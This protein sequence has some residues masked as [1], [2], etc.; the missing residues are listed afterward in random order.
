[1]Q[2]LLLMSSTIAPPSTGGEGGR[3][4]R[5]T[6]GAAS[7][8]LPFAE[9]LS[10]AHSPVLPAGPPAAGDVT[11]APPGKALPATGQILPPAT[12]GHMPAVT[13]V[14]ESPHTG[15]VA[16]DTA[17]VET[18]AVGDLDSLLEMSA[19]LLAAPQPMAGQSDAKVL[20]EASRGRLQ[21]S[22]AR[23]G[24]LAGDGLPAPMEALSIASPALPPA[25]LV[26]GEPA[27]IRNKLG[28]AT[29]AARSP[30]VTG[31]PPGLE[32]QGTRLPEQLDIPV[33][34]SQALPR[35]D[36]PS[37]L[38]ALDNLSRLAALQGTA[39]EP[40]AQPAPLLAEATPL[41]TSTAKAAA[42]GYPHAGLEPG[43]E[44][45]PGEIVLQV[46]TAARAS[47]GLHEATLQLHPAEL[48]RLQVTINAEGD[49]ARVVFTADNPLAK[50][51]IEAS[52][53]RLRDLLAQDGLQLV[54]AEVGHQGQSSGRDPDT[55]PA[56][57]ANIPFESSTEQAAEP[58][59]ETRVAATRLLDY[60]A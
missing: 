38:S 42:A 37:E 11:S 20:S 41:T 1:M 10:R 23:V 47:G 50:D 48:G 13:Q 35:A 7:G 2:S 60:Y 21:Q 4:S 28:A 55:A 22:S 27:L 16:P 12:A 39:A 52:L 49:Q 43:S 53:P 8:Q 45:F 17:E 32:S 24:G 6:P 19:A 40:G 18:P 33:R 54:Q 5:E 3:L 57:A 31:E 14:P 51:A 29:A 30:A 36:L 59:G 9:L 15:P 46:R 44:E 34:A 56:L 26:T 25:G 58:M